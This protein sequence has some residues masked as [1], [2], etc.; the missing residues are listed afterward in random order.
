MSPAQTYNNYIDRY[1][2]VEGKQ[3]FLQCCE[4]YMETLPFPEN[5]EWCEAYREIKNETLKFE[6]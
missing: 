6:I 3:L 2:E 5:I 1:G 4:F